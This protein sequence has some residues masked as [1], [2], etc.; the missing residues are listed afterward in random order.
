MEPVLKT[1]PYKLFKLGLPHFEG[2]IYKI[3]SHFTESR[4]KTF[5]N[6]PNLKSDE[7]VAYV[8]GYV[9]DEIVGRAMHFPTRVKLEKKNYDCLTG[10]ALEVYKDFQKYAVGADIMSYPVFTDKRYFVIAAGISEQALP[11][12]KKLRYHILNYDR[13]LKV[14]NFKS[15]LEYK[16]IKGLSNKIINALLIPVVKIH[17]KIFSAS[18]IHDFE[19]KKVSII[20]KSI[21]KISVTD[22]YRFMEVHDY[23]WLQWN[24]NNNFTDHPYN[25]KKFFI[26]YKDSKEFGFFMIKET[27]RKDAGRLKNVKLGSIIEW[28]SIDENILSELDIYK[29]A[30]PYFSKDIDLVEVATADKTLGKSLKKLGFLKFRLAHIVFKDKKKLF[31]DAKNIENWRIRLGYC[32]VGFT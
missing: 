13:Y 23:K 17:S 10:S 25:K 26:I 5:I 15:I 32:D 20:P 16:G 2:D 6:N 12:Y 4:R 30:L 21:N 19:I 11:L 3:A 7:E 31:P 1:F 9:D 14:Y 24:L 28:G 8:L 18:K 29:I 27:Y 22:K